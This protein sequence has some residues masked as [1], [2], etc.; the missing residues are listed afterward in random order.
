MDKY[1]QTILILLVPLI[2][3]CNNQTSENKNSI[4]ADTATI[5]TNERIVSN[6]SELKGEQSKITSQPPFTTTHV[7]TVPVEEKLTLSDIYKRFEKS[8]Q[9]FTILANKDTTIFCEEGTS[10]KI[11]A[12]SFITEKTKRE[13]TDKVKISVTEYFKLSDIVLSNL[14]TTAGKDILETG[15]MLY[16]SVSSNNDNCI[17]KQGQ[18]IEIGFP[19]STKKNDMQ[20]FSGQWTDNSIDWKPLK[21]KEKKQTTTTTAQIFTVVEEMP[22]YTG[23]EKEL[24]NYISENAKYPFSALEKKI[25]G[26]VYVTF[27]IDEFGLV[28]KVSILRGVDS[29]LDKV[30]Y[31]LVSKMPKWKAG[32]QR[33]K[34]VPVQLNLPIRFTLKGN[35]LNEKTIT[36]A[37]DFEEKIKNVKVV[38][39]NGGYST[40]DSTFKED[41][42]KNVNDSIIKTT[43][44][45]II[46]RY[47]FSTS[48]L[49]WIN[50]D[51]FYKDPQP[52]IDYYVQT[53]ETEETIIKIVFHSIKSIMI[54][55][56]GNYGYSF[57]NV[58][59]GEKITIV[60]FKNKNGG[61][62]LAVKETTIKRTRETELNFEPVTMALLKSQMERLDNIN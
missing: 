39:G 35:E 18:E 6:D 23:G 38:Y 13:I 10:I 30:A 59:L 60:A 9:T 47:I 21:V 14:T 37:K 20:L 7:A 41:F 17:L 57:V 45:S 4:T 55:N 34:P 40:S 28:T 5:Q 48:Q 31:S 42:E 49:G 51:R 33:N 58:P 22:A 50:C 54:G 27:V 61:V 19:Y 29:A 32:N 16:I 15:G 12:N 36:E 43:D 26:T 44:I 1:K 46:N 52:K 8:P 25:E 11:R 3:S 2:L 56:P 62:L 24:Q 53:N